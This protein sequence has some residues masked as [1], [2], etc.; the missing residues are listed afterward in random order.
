MDI[1]RESEELFLVTPSSSY[2]TFF[3]IKQKICNINTKKR[4]NKIIY[5]LDSG[6]LKNLFSISK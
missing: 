3:I 1:N 6:F 5:C 2:K 4:E